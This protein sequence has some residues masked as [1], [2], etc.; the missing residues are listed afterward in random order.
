MCPGPQQPGPG[1]SQAPA[2]EQQQPPTLEGEATPSAGVVTNGEATAQMGK[3][4]KDKKEIVKVIQNKR[5]EDPGCLGSRRRLGLICLSLL[6]VLIFMGCLM[7]IFLPCLPPYVSFP[8]YNATLP[9]PLVGRQLPKDWLRNATPVMTEMDRDYKGEVLSLLGPESL[10][11]RGETLFTGILGGHLLKLAPQDGKF[12]L[13]NV[14][15]FGEQCQD[16]SE[17]LKCGR[18]MGMRFHSDGLLYVTDAYLGLYSVNV[19]TGEKIRLAKSHEYISGQRSMLANDLDI[20]KDGTIYWSDASTKVKVEDVILE[21]M[22]EPSGRL[23]RYDPKTRKSEALVKR[24][25]CASGVQLSPDEDFVLVAEGGKDRILRYYLKGP[26]TGSSDIFIDG[27]P[28]VPDKIRKSGRPDGGYF[29]WCIISHGS[30][31]KGSGG[32]ILPWLRK[33]RILRTMLMR[34]LFIFEGMF[35]NAHRRFGDTFSQKAIYSIGNLASM[36]PFL[37]SEGLVLEIDSHG[38]I[39]GSFYSAD[40]SV[41][42]ASEMH[43]LPGGRGGIKGLGSIYF[44]SPVN[45]YLLQVPIRE[46][47]MLDMAM[48]YSKANTLPDVSNSL[49][50]SD[51]DESSSTPSEEDNQRTRTHSEELPGSPTEMDHVEGHI[52]LKEVIP[53]MNTSMDTPKNNMTDNSM[54]GELAFLERRVDKEDNATTTEN[55]TPALVDMVSTLVTSWKENQQSTSEPS[56]L[57]SF[58]ATADSLTDEDTSTFSPEEDT[59]EE[60]PFKIRL[61]EEMKKKKSSG[62]EDD[63]KGNLV[64]DD[65]VLRF[66]LERKRKFKEQQGVKAD[67]GQ[68]GTIREVDEERGNGEGDSEKNFIALDSII[69]VTT[70]TTPFPT[71]EEED[72]AT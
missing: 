62:E 19:D 38:N 39:T 45:P 53:V 35:Q 14:T 71:T 57:E 9:R 25:Q 31:A 29:V 72:V 7:L 40:Q 16:I 23:L 28:G 30:A 18:P 4:K 63:D 2:Q 22:S 15:K 33:H 10:A 6:G 67:F 24:I 36:A 12:S 20:A 66:L 27:L 54:S 26:K 59:S 52:G 1:E 42:M 8:E 47:A 3:A 70:V 32:G 17:S 55:L 44:A 48:A 61:Q 11:R 34:A 37:L 46:G 49:E 43:V 58:F 13:T 5:E 41:Y 64:L 56:L 68:N 60:D 51:E 65:A 69:D 21:F 50:D